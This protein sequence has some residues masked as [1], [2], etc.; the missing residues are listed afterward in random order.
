MQDGSVVAGT[1]EP[2]LHLTLGEDEALRG[3][4]VYFIRATDK[5]IDQDKVRT[6]RRQLV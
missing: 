6:P 3:K 1:G 2:R 4:A 5:P